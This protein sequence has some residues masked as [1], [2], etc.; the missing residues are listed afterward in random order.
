[1]IVTCV[2]VCVKEDSIDDFIE[3]TRKNH[4][5]SVAEPGNL[6]FDVLQS[7]ER[8]GRFMLYEAYRSEEAARAHKST[9]HYLEWRGA[10]ADWMEKPREGIA[11]DVISPTDRSM[12]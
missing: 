6:R 11:Y 8:P 5:E 4:L 3:A 1:M 12:W 10:V 9:E 2:H 7:R